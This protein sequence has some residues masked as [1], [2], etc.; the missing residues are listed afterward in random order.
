MYALNADRGAMLVENGA[1]DE[2][3]D[4]PH[5]GPEWFASLRQ[6]AISLRGSDHNMFTTHVDAAKGHRTA[7][8]ERPAVEWLNAQI[9]F[10]NW[11]AV[12]IAVLPPVRIGDW[13]TANGVEVS[14]NY[15]REDREGGLMALGGAL[16]G[17]A[18]EQL[19]A[20]PASHWDKL[21]SELTYESWAEK[22]LAAEQAM[23]RR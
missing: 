22:T 10:A 6:Q 23:L 18:R 3:M 16:P 17:I 11:T 4:I 9:H 1:A 13:A 20:L 5:H 2:V 19:M 7:W 21:R 8:V 15:E 12:T 14:K